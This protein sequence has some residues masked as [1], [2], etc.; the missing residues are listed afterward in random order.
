MTHPTHHR[1]GVSG[2]RC[3]ES[4]SPNKAALGCVSLPDGRISMW[5]DGQYGPVSRSQAVAEYDWLRSS[6]CPASRQ[7]AAEILA[8]INTQ[9]QTENTNGYAH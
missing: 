6:P 5:L 1:E 9:P 7:R 4:R 2:D 3:G 8:A